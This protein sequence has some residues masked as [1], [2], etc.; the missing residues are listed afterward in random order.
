MEQVGEKQD[1]ESALT[2][3]EMPHEDFML[4]VSRPV[5]A[6][7]EDAWSHDYIVTV[8][9]IALGIRRRYVGGPRR[10]WVAQFA[11]DVAQ[12]MYGHPPAVDTGVRGVAT[13][14]PR[15][16]RRMASPFQRGAY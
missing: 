4:R 5:E 6:G 12:G 11:I 3:H 2:R 14:W 13:M 7:Q 10:D 16:G 1:F 8:V 15:D 9:A